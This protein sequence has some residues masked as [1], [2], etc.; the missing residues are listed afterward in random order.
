MDRFIDTYDLP[1]L[2]HT[3]LENLDRSVT[4]IENGSVIGSQQG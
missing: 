1:K 3:D 2:R 4:K